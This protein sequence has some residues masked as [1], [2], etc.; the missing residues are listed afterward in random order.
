MFSLYKVLIQTVLVLLII[1]SGIT[2]ATSQ[3]QPTS[4]NGTLKL[5]IYY[6]LSI[7]T[8][9]LFLRVGTNA[10]TQAYDEYIATRNNKGA[11]IF[12]VKDTYSHG[13]FTLL[14]SR[15]TR[16]S[17]NLV[18]LGNIFWESG[19]DLKINLSERSYPTLPLIIADYNGKGSLKYKAWGEIERKTPELMKKLR[20]GDPNYRWNEVAEEKLS[21]L[22][23]YQNLISNLSY[24]LLKIK[25]LMREWMGATIA[26]TRTIPPID[27]QAIEAER[28]KKLYFPMRRWV[29]NEEA[30]ANSKDYIDFYSIY[31]KLYPVYKQAKYDKEKF[32]IA[33]IDAE[34]TLRLIVDSS[35]GKVRQALIV[36]LLKSLRVPPPYIYEQAKQYLDDP[37]YLN[38]LK[39]T[40]KRTNVHEYSFIDLQGKEVKLTNYNGKVMFVDTWFTGCPGCAGYY[41]TIVSKLEE[42][43]K[44]HENFAMVSISSDGSTEMWKE[45]I[46][47]GIYT[48]QSAI[49][50]YTG[51]AKMKHPMYQDLGIKAGPTV[52]LADKEG[53][54]LYF[55]TKELYDIDVLI[56]I[57]E[58]L[59]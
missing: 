34:S 58:R 16:R 18:L 15:A 5:E 38:Q 28:L 42:H 1:F 11:F 19:D 57:I 47:K 22:Y 56:D 27:S 45:S 54:L 13:Y 35:T 4:N 21:I 7:P 50:L 37:Y 44:G 40:N 23:K 48:N 55:N 26:M 24:D 41:R 30:L 17:D 31:F 49:N 9:T 43:F 3:G 36:K 39:E 10:L 20:S 52:L 6:N 32:P 2:S 14:K 51:G 12:L 25:I 46:T 29:E 59:L 33:N 8:D 53:N